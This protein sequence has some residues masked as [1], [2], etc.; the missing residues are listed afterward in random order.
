MKADIEMAIARARRCIQEAETLLGDVDVLVQRG[1]QEV[2]PAAEPLKEVLAELKAARTKIDTT[3]Q[4]I[5]EIFHAENV[6]RQEA[7]A[8]E[9]TEAAEQKKR[10]AT[11]H[12]EKGRRAA[13]ARA[14]EEEERRALKEGETT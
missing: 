8:K 14:K 4:G 10:E 11:E 5:G 2:G 1:A 6:K 7:R 3:S 13:E 12:A 9:R